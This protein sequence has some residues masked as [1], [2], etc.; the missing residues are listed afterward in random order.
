MN[1][2]GKAAN[3]YEDAG[4][5]LS[6]SAY[7]VNKHLGTTWLW[8]RV[9]VSGGAYGGFSDFDTHSGMFSYLSYRDPNLTKTVSISSHLQ[10][11]AVLLAHL[12]PYM[13]SALLP[14]LYAVC[15]PI[16]QKV[17]SMQS[18]SPKS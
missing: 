14:L 11:M 18:N 6:G 5:K 16:V 1:Y 3:L 10:P 12:F 17:C 9:R 2:V 8:D 15:S 13:Q 4:Y 7:V